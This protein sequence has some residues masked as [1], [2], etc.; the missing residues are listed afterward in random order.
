V[1][2]ES[3]SSQSSGKAECLTNRAVG[4]VIFK[5][6]CCRAMGALR[7]VASANLADLFLHKSPAF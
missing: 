6:N 2:R 4:R 7:G 1:E 3:L 5:C